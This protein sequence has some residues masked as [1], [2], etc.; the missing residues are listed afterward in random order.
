LVE[1]SEFALY[2]I[3]EELRSL[4]QH[5]DICDASIVPLLA[6]VQSESA[7]KSL[8]EQYHPYIIFHAAADKHVQLVEQNPVEGILNN[9][10]GT[11]NI[12]SLASEF[13]V[14]YFVLVSTDKA[15]RPT[16]IMG[17]SKRLAEMVLQALAGDSQKSKNTIFSIVRFGN[18]LN[19]SGSVVPLFRKQ[20]LQGG[21]VTLSHLEVTRFFM[22]IPEAAQLVIQASSMAKG[23]D[24][25][26]LDM[27]EP[28]K[29]FDLAKKIIELSGL[30]ILDQ[31]NPNGDIAIE[32]TGLSPAEKLYEELLISND[33]MP[34]IHPK[35]LKAH[36]QFLSLIELDRHLA[37]LK[38]RLATQTSSEQIKGLLKDLL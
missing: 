19:S 17:M 38:E 2:E 13:G 16:N 30:K 14:P 36:E 34:T 4:I 24:I 25:F 29:I 7:I 11:K 35:I 5:I 28:V 6:S 8:I 22:L 9:V 3:V 12:A 31:N 37:N 18:V 32:I 15:V 33:P 27:G 23:G 26:V 21:P 1:L 10:Y 20:I